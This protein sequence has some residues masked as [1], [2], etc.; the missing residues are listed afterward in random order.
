[1]RLL[2]GKEIRGPLM[3]Q[4]VKGLGD[5]PPK[6]LTFQMGNERDVGVL[7]AEWHGRCVLGKSLVPNSQWGSREVVGRAHPRGAPAEDT[8]H[9]GHLP[10]GSQQPCDAGVSPF[11]R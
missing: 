4:A 11:P 10:Q 1:M 8:L 3:V 2:L 9:L 5:H 7:E 6:A